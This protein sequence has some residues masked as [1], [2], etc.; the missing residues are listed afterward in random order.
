MV[1]GVN[2]TERAIHA[3]DAL[4]EISATAEHKEDFPNVS[5]FR[6]PVAPT[7]RSTRRISLG[8]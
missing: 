8:A 7:N 4:G 1:A 5:P 3:M 2:S 6:N